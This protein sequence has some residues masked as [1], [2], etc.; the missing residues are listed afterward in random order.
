LNAGV[1]DITDI[2]SALGGTSS[3]WTGK[4]KQMRRLIARFTCTVMSSGQY[5]QVRNDSP[6]QSMDDVIADKNA[7]L[8]AGMLSSQMANAYFRTHSVT[9]PEDD[10]N[11]C[12]QGVLDG[13]YNAYVHFNP[14][15]VKPG[16]RVINTGIV[17][18]VPLWV[19]G[20]P[21]QDQ[22]AIPDYMDNCPSIPN[23][24]LADS[25]DDGI[26]DVCD[27][28]RNTPN[29]PRG[30]TCT[31]GKVGGP[32]KSNCECG[33]DGACSMNQE[34]KNGNGTGDVCEPH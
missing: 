15:P 20:D 6:Y 27:N 32:C 31:K 4:P 34:D 33:D 13:V 10:I 21:D 3:G 2:N 23:P 1:F 16:L 30:G 29:G 12:G 22:D 18:G 11:V 8:C 25:D 9:L 5:L 14:N 28:C 19:A 26:G 24:D 17:T 7:K